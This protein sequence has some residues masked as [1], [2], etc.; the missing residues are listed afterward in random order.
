MDEPDTSLSKQLNFTSSLTFKTLIPILI[1]IIL[2][3][4]IFGFYISA[5]TKNNTKEFLIQNVLIPN[6]EQLAKEKNDNFDR[7]KSLTEYT[8]KEIEDR[9]IES[10]NR[11]DEET[12]ELYRR[13]MSKKPDGSY[14]SEKDKSKGR[15]QMAA[16]HNSI[17][18]PDTL[19]K[20][21]F[22]DA[23]LYFDPF[24]ESQ[25]PFV[26]TTYFATKNSIWQHGFPDWA[27]DSA[28]DETFDKYGWFYEADPVH[29]PNKRH[30]WTDMYYDELQGQWMISSLMPIY[31][32]NEF[33]GIVGQDFILQK[34]IETT[35]KHSIRETGML[36]FIDNL[37]NIVAHP[38]TESL[39]GKKAANDEI[40]NLKTI[41]DEALTEALR[42]LPNQ[43]G[44]KYTEEKNRRI[45]IYFSLKSV[46]WKMIYVLPEEELL[47][48][49]TQ[50]NEQYLTSFVLFSFFV[51][52][53][54]VSI[55]NLTVTRPIKKLKK[56]ITDISMGKLD[57]EIDPKIRN[58]RDEIGDL[59]QAFNR[60]IVSL[61]LAMKQ[62]APEL[63]KESEELKK[64]IGEKEKTEKELKESEEKLK[65]IFEGANDGILLADVETKKFSFANPKICSMTGYTKEELLKLDISRIH[66]QKDLPY[67]MDQVDRQIKGDIEVAK[68][69]PV[70]RKD[71]TL[72]YCDVNSKVIEFGGKRYI[73]GFFR[74]I[75]DRKKADSRK[76]EVK[77][78]KR[79]KFPQ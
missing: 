37:G 48:I 14:R 54:I 7:I 64:V 62:T 16:F 42:G 35:K 67:V 65:T 47:K 77:N 27:L 72:I 24:C 34:I 59:A 45:V 36:F 68:D 28:A 25:M 63:M 2:I 5:Q 8:S 13:Y 40:L 60:T 31:D 18:S 75:S 71:K 12:N 41:P 39:I 50:T 46:N 17:T 66:P 10:K 55:I 23:F 33:L 53:I 79:Q 58:S 73:V 44:F 57:T 21:I 51:I 30:V 70:L 9:I 52:A 32:E 76:E 15:F 20:G 1:V 22:A 6:F 11:N 3:I 26:F 38:D 49:I 29:N 69:I 43:N 78:E 56:I 74:D 4:G 61:K 19:E